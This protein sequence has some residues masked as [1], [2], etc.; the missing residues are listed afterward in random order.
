MR[1]RNDVRFGEDGDP[2]FTSSQGLALD[3]HNFRRRIFKPAASRAGISWA[4]PHML[5]HGIAT[6]MA[7]KGYSPAQIAAQ[8]GHADG[9]VLALRT[10]V[11]AEPIESTSFIDEALGF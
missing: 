7:E 1:R 8:L 5:R 3:P 10:Y 2:V 11:R 9:G 6:L 4:S